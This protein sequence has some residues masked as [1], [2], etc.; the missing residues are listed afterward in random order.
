MGVFAASIGPLLERRLGLQV[1]PLPLEL[2]TLPIYMVWHETR[3]L[4]A[5]HRWLRD[6]VAQEIGPILA[7]HGLI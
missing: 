2:S 6:V 5:A 1:I 3:G 4:D 7:L